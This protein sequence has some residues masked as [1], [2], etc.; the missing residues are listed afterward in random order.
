MDQGGSQWDDQQDAPGRG[1]AA[2]GRRPW[3][4]LPGRRD[5]APPAVGRRG[6][7]CPG[8][9]WGAKG[10]TGSTVDADPSRVVS[11]AALLR[12]PQFR[13]CCSPT[14]SVQGGGFL[15]VCSQ[16]CANVTPWALQH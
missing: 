8:R 16:R 2:G 9:F 10:H 11:V 3:R 1:H 4:Q 6:L 14:S 12:C 13:L 15:S 5:A 7:A